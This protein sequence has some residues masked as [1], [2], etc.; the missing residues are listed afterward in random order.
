MAQACASLRRHRLNELWR[1]GFGYTSV[2]FPMSSSCCTTGR[3]RLRDVN[4]RIRRH[5]GET[6][7]QS[8]TSST[9]LRP[10]L[11]RVRIAAF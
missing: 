11:H 2:G 10:R 4:R 3:Q 6:D 9:D 1:F 8:A 7:E 5:A